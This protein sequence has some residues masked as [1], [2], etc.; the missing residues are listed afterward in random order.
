VR[1]AAPLWL[2]GTALALAVAALLIA[3][4]VLRSRNLKKFGDEVLVGGLLTAQAGGRRALKGVLCVLA[5]ALAFVA[6]AQP[7]YGRGTRLIPA[8]NL[9][10]VVVLDYSKS[11][12]ARDIAPSR[13]QRAKSEVA[14]LIS[15]LPGARFGAV[16]F[17]GE[18]ISFPLT[19]DGPA[20]SQFFQQM[21]PNDMPVGGTAIA[22][23]LQ[24]GQELL[25]RDP[26]SKSHKRVMLL[27][28]DGEDLEGD[29]VSVATAAAQEDITISVVQIGGRTPEPIPQVTETG[30]VR[31]MRTDEEG[32]PLTT[33][34]SA[35]GEAQLAGIASKTGGVV[36]RSESGQTGIAE[37]ER[38]L[39]QLMTE[40]LSEK[41]E[42]IYAD[43]YFYPL[44]LALLLVLVET[45]VPEAK[46]RK[47][48][49]VPPPKK[50]RPRR[51]ASRVLTATLM[52]AFGFAWLMVGCAKQRNELWMRN[53][54]AV[55][56]AIVALDAGDAGAAVSLLEDY[57]ATGK[58]EQSNIGAPESV[59]SRPNATFDLGL[60][61]FKLG[62]QYGLRFG[63]ED[64][65][66]AGDKTGKSPEAQAAHEKRSSEVEC[67]LRIVRIIAADQTVP[68]DLRARAFYLAGN[69]E[70]L[71][72][73]YESAVKGYDA[74]LELIPGLPVDGG[75]GIGRDAAFNRGIALG[76]IED[77]KKDAGPDSPP[78]ASPDSGDPDAGPPDG[79]QDPDAG[80]P[81][82]G[83][84]K[85]Q[86]GG[87]PDA[88]KQDQP[89]D[90]D[91]GPPDAGKQ[92]QDQQ[93]Q[94]QQPE[95]PKN[96]DERMLDMLERAPS[97]QRQDA[98]NRS[99]SNRPRTEDK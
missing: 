41:V 14:R 47:P 25:A 31:G 29:P 24:A 17:A 9:D 21:T 33:S 10:L 92:P 40:E 59:R 86:D 94:Q 65:P 89:K 36:V 49:R 71:R 56:E 78:D 67:A 85:Q 28:T 57:L 98:K 87:P 27:V 64:P 73:D 5:V 13:T 82:K 76:R 18:P 70:F 62:E 66:S 20:I 15:S 44:G 83:D 90:Q 43:V 2:F 96:Q 19:S 55:D 84:Q 39:K 60:G 45:F 93:P 51:R 34:L 77:K 32:K 8:T 23:A 30:E 52:L 80:K 53:A 74:S 69:L 26:L 95:Q 1:F 46:A 81:E 11:M 58:C 38:R 35:D 50:R 4:S 12:Y 99:L 37:I 3:G 88:G 79:G 48:S 16:A 61:L 6:A 63:E 7:Q 68:I 97:V 22:R 91:G 72:G 54:P 42:T 75:D